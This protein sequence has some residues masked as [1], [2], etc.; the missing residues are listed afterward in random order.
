MGLT[1]SEDFSEAGQTGVWLANALDGSDWEVLD[2]L[3][4]QLF[5]K[6]EAQD[7]LIQQLQADV[8]DWMAGNRKI[9]WL[10]SQGYA[11]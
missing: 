9:A 3:M 8:D 7:K 2:V 4:P 6:R 5:R 1:N 11:K 10:K